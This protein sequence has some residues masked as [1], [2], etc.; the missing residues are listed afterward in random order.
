MV[1]HDLVR[2]SLHVLVKIFRE[3]RTFPRVMVLYLLGISY[4]LCDCLFGHSY[5]FLENRPRLHA[6][7][8]KIARKLYIFLCPLII[9]LHLSCDILLYLI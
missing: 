8:I 3:A 6:F 7:C 1:F 5:Y 9:S 2:R 4:W